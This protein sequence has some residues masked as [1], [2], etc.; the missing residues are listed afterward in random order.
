MFFGSSSSSTSSSSRA[1]S[2]LGSDRAHTRVHTLKRNVPV[3]VV[4]QKYPESKKISK[5]ALVREHDGS[6]TKHPLEYEDAPNERVRS[7]GVHL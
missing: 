5:Y 2:T 7:V 1:S 6:I 3:S 4:T